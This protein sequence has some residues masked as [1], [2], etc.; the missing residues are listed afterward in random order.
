MS[1]DGQWYHVAGTFDGAQIA[2][3]LNGIETD[4]KALSGIAS[5]AGELLIGDGAPPSLGLAILGV[6]EDKIDIGVVSV[7]A[8]GLFIL[9]VLAIFILPAIG[10]P[11]PIGFKFLKVLNPFTST[12]SPGTNTSTLSNRP[13]IISEG[14]KL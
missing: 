14:E 4:A 1:K 5:S 8:A 13:A 3:Y 11:I 6:T 9:A 12:D 10:I 2:C 7:A